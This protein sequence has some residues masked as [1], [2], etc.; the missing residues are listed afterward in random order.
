MR[1]APPLRALAHVAVA[2]R[3]EL[4]RRVQLRG[5]AELAANALVWVLGGPGGEGGKPLVLQRLVVLLLPVLIVLVDL[6]SEL[7]RIHL[8][9]L[10]RAACAR[11]AIRAS[12]CAKL[13]H[14]PHPLLAQ[15][16]RA[17]AHQ[18]ASAS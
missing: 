8:P 4:I 7:L 11:D 1:D 15:L 3:A 13:R 14:A 12:Q 10:G 2:Q 17:C 18:R 6:D 16:A 5:G 9:L